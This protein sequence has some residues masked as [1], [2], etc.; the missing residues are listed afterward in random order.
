MENFREDTYGERIAEIY[1]DLYADYDPAAIERLRELAQGGRAL[2]LGI[3]TGRIALPLQAAGVPV[4]GV[5]ASPAMVARMGLKPGG[6]NLISISA[7]SFGTQFRHTVSAHSFG[8][9]FRHT[10]SAHVPAA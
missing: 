2:E 4:S 9:Q 10:V 1:D 3:G 5:E 8:T 7:H 6:E